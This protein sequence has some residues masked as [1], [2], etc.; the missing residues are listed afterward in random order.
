M[1]IWNISKKRKKRKLLET[2]QIAYVKLEKS[3]AL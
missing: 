2:N 3:N 1:G